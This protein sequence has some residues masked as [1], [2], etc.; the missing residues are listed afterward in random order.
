MDRFKRLRAST[1]DSNRAILRLL[2][3]LHLVSDR[4]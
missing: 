1:E 3:D 4:R 2:T